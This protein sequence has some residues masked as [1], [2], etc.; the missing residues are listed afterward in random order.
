MKADLT[1]APGS[2]DLT[3]I[4]EW[5]A[6]RQTLVIGSLHPAEFNLLLPVLRAQA[7]RG[8]A[9]ILA[10]RNPALAED[11]QQKLQSAGITSC[12]RS[13]GLT[14]SQLMLLDTM[15]ELAAVYALAGVAFVGGSLVGDVGGHNPLEV[16]QQSVPLLMGPNCRNFADLVEELKAAEAMLGCDDAVAT[17]IAIDRVL[18]DKDLAGKMVV[19]ADRV[20][21]ENRGVLPAT[22]QLV[23]DCLFSCRDGG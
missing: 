2:V 14:V 5:I 15:G 19:N 20:L 8:R 7:G 11:W 10:P 3:S 9:I 6:G 21:R 23:K 1:V 17:G 18:T 4:K 16:I 22:L 12:R 13:V